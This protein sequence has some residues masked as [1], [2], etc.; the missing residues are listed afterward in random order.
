MMPSATRSRMSSRTEFWKYFAIEV[1]GLLRDAAFPA[2]AE[3]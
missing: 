1:A 2:G 3:R